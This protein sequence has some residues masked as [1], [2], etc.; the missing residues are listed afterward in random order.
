MAI[1]SNTVLFTFDPA[2]PRITAYDIHEWLQ[3][4]IHIQEQKVQTIEI[5]GIKRQVFVKMTDKDYMSIIHST[6]GSGTYTHHTGEISRVAIAVAG[7]GCKKLRVANLPPE[8]MDDTLRTALAPFGQIMDIQKEKWARTYRYIVDNGIRQVT[9]VLTQ[10]VPSHL[11]IADQ[12]VL[13]SYDGQP[14][15]CYGCG[16]TGHIYPTC[17]RRQRRKQLPPLHAPVTYA[18]IA[19]TMPHLTGNQPSAS[20]QGDSTPGID[21]EMESDG[22]I[23]I[24]FLPNPNAV[25]PH[26]LNTRYRDGGPPRPST[27]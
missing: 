4:E 24:P 20:Q 11:V 17:P 25:S 21:R 12:R 16:E 10:H 2:S 5:D 7:I 19:A 27:S 1:H 8:V 14:S 15:T 23:M 9:M 13:I 18:A 22:N 26:G 6:G 3:E